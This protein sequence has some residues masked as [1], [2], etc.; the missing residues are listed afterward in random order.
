MPCFSLF[1]NCGFYRNTNIRCDRLK[2]Y[3]NGTISPEAQISRKA[4][5]LPYVFTSICSSLCLR[6]S[7]F[8]AHRSAFSSSLNCQP[9]PLRR[10]LIQQQHAFFQHINSCVSCPCLSST[11]IHGFGF[12]LYG[13]ACP[14]ANV[15]NS[16]AMNAGGPYKVELSQTSLN[17]A[18]NN[19]LSLIHI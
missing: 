1:P 15:R 10:L 19:D 7:W 17:Q 5:V 13:I 3:F 8:L 4:P 9:S 6:S 12:A 18:H 11:F 2:C 14:H 16:G